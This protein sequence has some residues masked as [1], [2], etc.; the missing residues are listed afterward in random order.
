MALGL[1]RSAQQAMSK[2]IFMLILTKQKVYFMGMKKRESCLFTSSF[3]TSSTP[4]RRT[5]MHAT[6][7]SQGAY[8]GTITLLLGNAPQTAHKQYYSQMHS[9]KLFTLTKS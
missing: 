5:Y 2:Y 7:L 8:H 1:T 6:L 9:P 3:K 4:L